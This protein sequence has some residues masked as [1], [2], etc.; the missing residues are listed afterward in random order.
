M[1]NQMQQLK[2]HNACLPLLPGTAISNKKNAVNNSQQLSQNK[3]KHK[4]HVLKI[5][6]QTL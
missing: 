6:L 1:I 5:L 2:Y 3:Y 4:N